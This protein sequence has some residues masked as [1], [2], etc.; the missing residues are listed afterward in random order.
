NYSA[1]QL[2]ANSHTITVVGTDSHSVSTTLGPLTITVVHPSVPVGNL[3]S[4]VDANTGSTSIS[5]S[6]G[7]SLYVGGWAA[8][9]TDNGPAKTVQISIDGGTPVAA[10]LGISRPDVAAYYNNSAWTN[11]G[12]QL[13]TSVSGLGTG[14]HSVTAVAKDSVGNSTT[15][16]PLTFTVAP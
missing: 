7:D 9:Y 15:L 5:K 13:F 2:S 10:T 4:A 8:D 1:A 12:F 3:D 14:S 6:S 11:S 16:G